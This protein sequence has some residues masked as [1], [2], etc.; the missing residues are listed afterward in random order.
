MPVS[1]QSATHHDELFRFDSVTALVS[2]VRHRHPDTE[3]WTERRSEDFLLCV[4]GA[5]W[6]FESLIVHFEGEGCYAVE[7]PGA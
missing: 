1:P 4:R 7:L 2:E 3:V 5:R 6:A